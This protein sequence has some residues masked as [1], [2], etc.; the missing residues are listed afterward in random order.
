[1]RVPAR[2]RRCSPA[3]ARPSGSRPRAG[4]VGGTGAAVGR[5][6]ADGTWRG[7]AG[8]AA[9][10]AVGATLFVAAAPASG[11]A[12]AFWHPLRT[13]ADARAPV[14]VSVDRPQVHRGDSVTV[15]VV[16]PGAARATLWRRGPGEPWR[17]EVVPLG[18]VGRA[19]R[20][21]GPLEHD[22]YL[23]AS[24]GGRRSAEVRVAVA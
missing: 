2:S 21:V 20:R 23:R 18:E 19:A 7:L 1:M 4:G 13:L 14:R 11:R 15:T 24:S 5:T 9:V 6:L 10:A 17:A 12:A 3:P 22:L 16:A 8:A